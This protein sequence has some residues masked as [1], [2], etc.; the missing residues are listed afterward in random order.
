MMEQK[1]C[2]M[3]IAGSNPKETEW[4]AFYRNLEVIEKTKTVKV[5]ISADSRYKLYINMIQII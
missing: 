2:W 4:V 5:H 3:W 1:S